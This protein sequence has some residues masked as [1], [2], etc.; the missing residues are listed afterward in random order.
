MKVQNFSF[1]VFHNEIVIGR[2]QYEAALKEQGQ[3]KDGIHRKDLSLDKISASCQLLAT[4]PCCQKTSQ[5]R[6]KRQSYLLYN[7]TKTRYNMQ[8]RW[9]QRFSDKEMC[10]RNTSEMRFSLKKLKI[11]FGK[12]SEVIG[13]HDNRL[14]QKNWILTQS[15][16]LSCKVMKKN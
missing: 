6:M 4:P 14:V 13:L 3:N 12:P 8:R 11:P 16:Y 15:Q 5:T 9:L 1:S 7:Q 2:N 10:T